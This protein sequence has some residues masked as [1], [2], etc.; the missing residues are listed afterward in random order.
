L[1]L[2]AWF[3]AVVVATVAVTQFAIKLYQDNREF[4]RKQARNAADLADKIWASEDCRRAIALLDYD[5]GY[6][7][8][9]GIDEKVSIS[10]TEFHHA[11]RTTNLELSE[12]EIAIRDSTMDKLFLA[13][14]QMYAHLRVGLVA[15]TDVAI[16]L[17]YPIKLLRSDVHR[18]VAGDYA[19]K[20]DL[21]GTYSIITNAKR[22]PLPTRF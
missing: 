18:D 10:V 7:Q 8:L 12:Q 9:P 4:R 16:L 15:W 17:Y 21:F 20:F 2:A 6:H 11:L 3:A 13:F 19:K 22:Y 14:E 1:Q 5:E